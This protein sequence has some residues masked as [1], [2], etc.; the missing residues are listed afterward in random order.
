VIPP[1]SFSQEKILLWSLG[2]KERELGKPF[3][4]ALYGRGRQIGPLLESEKITRDRLF[5][6]LSVVGA[7]CSCEL[8]RNWIKGPMIPL[9]WEEKIQSKLAK[10][11]GFDPENPMVKMEVSQILSTGEKK[12]SLEA[13]LEDTLLYGYKED[14]VEYTKSPNGE[15]SLSHTPSNDPWHCCEPVNNPRFPSP[16]ISLTQT[17]KE[18]PHSDANLPKADTFLRN[19]LFVIGIV[20]LLCMGG[21]LL[22]LR[23]RR[24][25]F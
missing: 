17:K 11:L 1:D 21:G 23:K 22:V 5:N 7:D 19:T 6:I 10:L 24:R 13:T 8:D 3:V 16:T 4:T 14:V 25:Q 12:P 9:K 20:L 15:V 18:V 2:L